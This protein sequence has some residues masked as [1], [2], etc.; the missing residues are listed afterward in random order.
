MVDAGLYHDSIV[1]LLERAVFDKDV[2]RGLDVDS[3]GV[4][5]VAVDV[6]SA[7]D[8]ILAAQEVNRPER[9]LAYRDAFQ[10]HT[11]AAVELDE[12]RTHQAPV[13]LPVLAFRHRRIVARPF[14]KALLRRVVR[15]ILFARKPPCAP[16][17]LYGRRKRA[18]PR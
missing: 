2:A 13:E 7:Y 9:R 5:E 11:L 12:R 6:K 17:R 8:D 3:V 15:R 1:A 18:L 14:S 16:A 4:L 10:P